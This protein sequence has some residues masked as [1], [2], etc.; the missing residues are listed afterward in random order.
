MFVAP[1]DEP[2]RNLFGHVFSLA[3]HVMG[4]LVHGDRLG[5]LLSERLGEAVLD[6]HRLILRLELRR[7]VPQPPRLLDL[8]H[9]RLGLGSLIIAGWV[10]ENERVRWSL[11]R[12]VCLFP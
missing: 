5:V 1:G 9:E 4:L 8:G 3:A 7:A 6:S 12:C 11:A 10:R 2:I